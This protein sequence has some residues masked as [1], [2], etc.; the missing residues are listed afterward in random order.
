MV[1]T[2]QFIEAVY[3]TLVQPI[4]ENESSSNVYKF[5]QNTYFMTAVSNY[6]CIVAYVCSIGLKVT[7]GS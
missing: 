6:T 5:V 3:T 4:T 2:E 1:Q 7:A